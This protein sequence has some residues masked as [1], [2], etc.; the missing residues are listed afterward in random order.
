[1]GDY[2]IRVLLSGES[3]GLP[4][5]MPSNQD[6]SRA[7]FLLRLQGRAVPFLFQPLVAAGAFL[8]VWLYPP[9]LWLCGHMS[10]SS[11]VSSQ[12]AP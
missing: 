12:I 2:S 1:M 11:S 9:N 4:A 6:V 8:G 7:G 10:F 5:Q 3:Q